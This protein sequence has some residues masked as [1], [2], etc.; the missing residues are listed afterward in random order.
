MVC[1]NV[2]SGGGLAALNRRSEEPDEGKQCDDEVDQHRDEIRHETL[3]EQY[4]GGVE[5]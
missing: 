3:A 4:P 2:L 5:E 1:R